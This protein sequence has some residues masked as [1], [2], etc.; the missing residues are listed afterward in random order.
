[1]LSNNNDSE[2][3]LVRHKRDP[4]FG[5]SIEQFE[6][7]LR[8]RLAGRV[9]NAFFFGSYARKELHRFSDIDLILIK[10][11]EELFTKRPIEFEDLLDLNPGIQ[12]LVYNQEEFSKLINSQEIGFWAD[13]RRDLLRLI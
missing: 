9:K 3:K 13:V 8:Q 7:E 10:E 6:Q 12:M 4:L 2:V 11:T 5:L 1:M